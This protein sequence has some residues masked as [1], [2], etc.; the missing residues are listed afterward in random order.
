M[1]V[2]R[3]ETGTVKCTTSS[4]SMLWLTLSFPLGGNLPFQD[5]EAEALVQLDFD[6]LKLMCW[7]GSPQQRGCDQDRYP[8]GSPFGLK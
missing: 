1:R 8:E 5:E 2:K 7:R 6:P 4:W 3:K